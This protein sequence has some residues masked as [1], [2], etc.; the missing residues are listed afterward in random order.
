MVKNACHNKA[1]NSLI[2]S[3]NYKNLRQTDKAV[4]K[5]EQHPIAWQKESLIY[6]LRGQPSG[7]W[8]HL[9]S[10]KEKKFKSFYLLIFKIG[11][12]SP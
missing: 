6:V 12:A 11:I 4:V 3:S 9:K 5:A 2:L 1:Y 10:Q 7:K 8:I